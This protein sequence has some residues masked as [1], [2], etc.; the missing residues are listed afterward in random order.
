MGVISRVTILITHIR[1]LL[2]LLITTH[3]PP[4][5]GQNREHTDRVVGKGIATNSRSPDATLKEGLSRK[6]H[7]F[8]QVLA[9][10]PMVQDSLAVLSVESFRGCETLILHKSSERHNMLTEPKPKIARP[11]ALNL[12]V[13]TRATKASRGS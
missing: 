13:S 9:W 1:G 12:K 7:D 6:E 10:S 3:E 4:G 5:S 2:T 8:L 11:N